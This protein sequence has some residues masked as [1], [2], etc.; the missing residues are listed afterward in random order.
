[1]L[2]SVVSREGTAPLAAVAGYKVGGKTGTAKKAIQ[3]GYADKRYQA[4][5]AGIAPLD[6]PRLVLVVMIDEPRAGKFY[7]GAVAAPV[8][9]KVMAGALRMLDISPDE[10]LLKSPQVAAVKGAG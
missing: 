5:F 9:S 10:T 8:F 6:E 7:G 1:M 2:A 4:V 3:G